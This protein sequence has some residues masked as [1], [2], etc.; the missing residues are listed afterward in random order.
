M[1]IKKEELIK[2]LLSSNHELL[3]QII[4]NNERKCT[5]SAAD[6]IIKTMINI[7][8]EE[9]IDVIEKA[10]VREKFFDAINTNDVDLFSMFIE[11]PEYTYKIKFDTLKNRNIKQAL[12]IGIEKAMILN[13]IDANKEENNIKRKRI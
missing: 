12:E 10:D 13:N 9:I 2:D 3:K 5:A 6:N 4:I 11:M 7:R 8:I 1:L